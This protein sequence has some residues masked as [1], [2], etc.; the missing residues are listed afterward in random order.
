METKLLLNKLQ[1]IAW[2]RDQKDGHSKFPQKYQEKPTLVI[3]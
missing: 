2:W 3:N 1:N